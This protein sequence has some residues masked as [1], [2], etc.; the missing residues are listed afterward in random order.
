MLVVPAVDL[1]DGQVVR[2]RQGD[3]GAQQVYAHDPL[4]VIRRFVEAGA[5]R[6]HLVDL[7]GARLGRPHQLLRVLGRVRE[8]FPGL[9][10]QV[11]G[12]L[13]DRQAVAEALAAGATR[14]LLGT[15][16]VRQPDLV[17]A[18]VERFGAERVAVAVDVREGRV[19]VSGWREGTS[20]T[21][22]E[23]LAEMA[24]L[25][26]RHALVTDIARDGMLSGPPVDL[27][28]GLSRVP[29]Q[30]TASGGVRDLEHVRTLLRLG[31]L[32]AVVVGRAVY[33]GTLDLAEAIRVAEEG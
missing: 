23:L 26:V 2:L 1:K 16:A 17:G 3:F 14:V 24:G 9:E 21:P 30:L 20:R 12:G 6:V 27:L 28:A 10:V 32:E 7:D 13:R 5:R 19:H 31:F 25:G 29:V 11:G 8:A 33:E 4:A 15:A 22:E 18:L